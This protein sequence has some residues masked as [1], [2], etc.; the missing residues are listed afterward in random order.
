MSK[1]NNLIKE[2]NKSSSETVV[3]VGLPTYEFKRIPFTSPRMN[4][5]TFGG[6]PVGKLIEFYGEEHGGKTTSAL[7]IIANYQQSGDNRAVLYVD[8]E[9]TLDAEWA[10]TMGVDVDNLIL[11][12]PTS[13]SAEEILQFI[14]DAIDTG[15]IGLWVLDSIGALSSKQELEKTLDEKTYA[16]ISAPLTVFGRKAEMLMTKHHCTGIGINQLRDDLG[17]MWAGATKTPGGRGWR[18]YCAVRLQFSKGKYI[19]ENG[20]ELTSRAE[21]PAGNYVLMSMTKNKTCPPTRRTGFYTLNYTKGV[22]YLKDLV[23]VAIKYDIVQ[24]SGAWYS[25]VDIETGEKLITLQGSSK[26]YAYLED[27]ENESTLSRIEAL[28]ESFQ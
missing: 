15:E 6:L 4:Y 23:D 12:K 8:A 7:D 13:Q 1:L 26:L 19:D 18:H 5:C 10:R 2:F 25:I 9:N 21:S 16:G 24:K 3:S 14:L 28:V 11:F 20:V 17:A 27:P 22:D